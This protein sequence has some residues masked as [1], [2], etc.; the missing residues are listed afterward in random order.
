MI[1]RAGRPQPALIE[2]VNETSPLYGRVAPGDLLLSINGERPRDFIDYLFLAAEEELRLRVLSGERE[3][4]LELNGLA[5]ASLGLTF[6]EPVFDGV[7]T[8]SSHCVFCFVDRMPAGLRPSLYLKDDDYR[9]SVLQGNFITLNNL[10]GRDLERILSLHLSPLYVSLHSSDPDLRDRMMGGRYSRRA[11]EHL[12]TLID[13]G[14]ETHLQVVLCPG[15]N[16]G[17]NLRFTLTSILGDY[18]VAS[19]GI[20][21]VGL[22]GKSSVAVALAPV[23]KE[24]ATCVLETVS[25]FQAR[26]LACHGRRLFYVADEFYILAEAPF[27]S[28]EEYE[29]YPQLENGIGMA[30]DFIDAA[31][32][33]LSRQKTTRPPE[34]VAVL[35]GK[36]GGMVLEEALGLSGGGRVAAVD[37]RPV[38]NGLFGPGVTVTG[39]VAGEDVLREIEELQGYERILVPSVML[40][41]GEFLDSVNISRVR[42][43]TRASIEVV[44]TDGAQLVRALYRAGEGN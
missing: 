43:A 25:E 29:D 33:E 2:G 44:D 7:R 17:E 24:D 41:E 26:A 31:R 21:P 32:A 38:T 10:S 30:R 27:P 8:C 20:V 18:P 40:R 23:G 39:L 9:L 14:V 37:I 16:D 34:R 4:T 42:Q 3:K 12:R 11:L 19:A 36:L 13:E 35:T 28:G 15:I 1:K 5:G 22:S 6:T